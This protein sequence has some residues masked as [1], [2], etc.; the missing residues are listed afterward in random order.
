MTFTKQTLVK[1]L[2]DNLDL[3]NNEA[4][5]IVECLLQFISNLGDTDK[6]E[7]RKFGT[8]TR[9]TISTVGKRNPTTGDLIDGKEYTTLR[10]KASPTLRNNVTPLSQP[11]QII[12]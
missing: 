1:L 3:H 2:Q 8:F 11:G 4:E 5:R 10:F 7:I 6:I 9:K 12:G